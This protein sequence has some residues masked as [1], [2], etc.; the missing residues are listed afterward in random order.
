MSGLWVRVL[1]AVT[2]LTLLAGIGSTPVLAS[3][4]VGVYG[5]R[6]VPDGNDAQEYSDPGWGGGVHVVAPLPQVA[7][8][9][10]VV[11]GFEIINLLSETKEFQDGFTGLRVEQQTSQNYLRFFLGGQVG[12]HGH[13]FFRPHAGIN[14]AL[15][16]YGVDT[17]VVIPDDSDRENEIRQNLDKENHWTTGY[18]ITLGIDLNFDNEVSVDGGVRY[19]KTFSLPQQLGAD[20]VTIHPE[21]FQVYL[22]VGVSFDFIRKQKGQGGD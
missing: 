3:G 20:S 9:F 13:G 6:M 18:D 10:A 4:K 7:N 8:V 15:I 2:L 22:G 11:A 21:Y 16:N 5:I 14:L 17:D 12:G 19:L 1:V